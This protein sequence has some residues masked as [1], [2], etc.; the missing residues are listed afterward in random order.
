MS[1]FGKPNDV[2]WLQD[3][4]PGDPVCFDYGNTYGAAKVDRVTDTLIIV[5]HE[6]YRKKDGQMIGGDRWHTRYLYRPTPEIM[7]V[8][9]RNRLLAKLNKFEWHKFPT[10]TLAAIMEVVQAATRQDSD[11]SLKSGEQT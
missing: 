4:K 5:G 8:V 7:E 3:V 2:A 9:R 1:A 6:R 10:A 11:N